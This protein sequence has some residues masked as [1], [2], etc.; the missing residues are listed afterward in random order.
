V[1]AGVIAAGT[2]LVP[3]M[4]EQVKLGFQDA[5]R[6][7]QAAGIV[8]NVAGVAST[9]SELVAGGLSA[10]LGGFKAGTRR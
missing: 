2:E 4:R 6:G 3:L 7:S 9:S 8:E 1:K 5:L 10:L